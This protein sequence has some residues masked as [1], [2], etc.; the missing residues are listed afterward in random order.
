MPRLGSS[1]SPYPRSLGE[2]ISPRSGDFPH[3]GGRET[4]SVLIEVAAVSALFCVNIY[5]SILE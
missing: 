3:S 1:G 4:G 5:Y 2:G